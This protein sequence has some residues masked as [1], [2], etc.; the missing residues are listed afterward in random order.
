LATTNKQVLAW[1][2]YDWANSAFATVVMAGF[3]PVFF[4]EYWSAGQESG[5]VTLHLG[6]ANSIAGLIVIAA[7]PVLG[8]IADQAA[9]RKRFLLSFAAFGIVM[10]GAM[11]WIEQGEWLLAAAC[12]S[13]AAIGFA[14][15]NAFYDSLLVSVAPRARYDQVSALGYA[16]GY[17]GGGLLFALCVLMYSY[18]RTFGF[19]SGVQVVQASFLLVALWW[20]IFALPLVIGVSE[21]QDRQ[22]RGAASALRA[23]LRQL[24]TT[25][26]QIRQLR[27]A[28]LFLAAYWLYIDGVDTVVV[29][30]VDYGKSLGFA[31]G[32]LILAL[33]ITQFVGFPATVAF[34]YLGRRLGTKR[35][36]LIGIG[37][38]ILVLIWG[39]G[40]R[41]AWEFYALAVA[42]GLVQGGVQSLSRAFFARL[43]PASQSAEL[44]GFYNL[45]GK[46]AAIIGPTLVGWV[47]VLTGN[48]RLGILSLLALFIAGAGLLM[49]VDD[50]R[51]SQASV[52]SVAA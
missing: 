52:G 22:S 25:V 49:F 48:P 46:F 45:L 2:V 31:T 18:P 28:A 21:K 12:Y 35:G 4:R 10:T 42:I 30:A 19:A 3:F 43:I 15:A 9:L 44:F 33:L 51:A 39:A 6:A 27:M 38:Y 1:A 16:L 37:M 23:G 7:A 50:E 14:G 5:A 41:S 32:D 36:I 13:L 26:G 8:A 20:T 47:G 40:I 17:L 34:G 24:K 11:F 29:L